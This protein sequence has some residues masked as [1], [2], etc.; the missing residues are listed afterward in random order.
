MTL[1]WRERL[2]KTVGGQNSNNSVRVNGDF[3]EKVANLD[4]NPEAQIE[5][6][7]RWIIG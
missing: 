4:N 1:L 5:L 3:M 2:I 6:V 7:G